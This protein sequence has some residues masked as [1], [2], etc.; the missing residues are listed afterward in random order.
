VEGKEKT[1]RNQALNKF[2]FYLFTLMLLVFVC[3][4]I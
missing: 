3:K 2:I 4:G 1:Y